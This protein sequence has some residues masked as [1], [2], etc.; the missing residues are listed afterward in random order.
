MDGFRIN[1]PGGEISRDSQVSQP[2]APPSVTSQSFDPRLQTTPDYGALGPDLDF[3]KCDGASSTPAATGPANA[4]PASATLLLLGFVTIGLLTMMTGLTVALIFAK[5]GSHVGAWEKIS[6]IVATQKDSPALAAKF[7]EPDLDGQKP[8]KQAEILLTRAVSHSDGSSAQIEEQIQSRIE[9][10][11]GKVKW[12]SQLSQLTMAAFNSEDENV[13]SSAI[14]VQL[15]AYGLGKNKSSVD[16]LVRKADSPD[17]AQK[18][19]ALWALGL[20]GNR[21]IASDRVVQVL[22]EHIAGA[23]KDP[24]EDSRHWAVEGLAL[25]GNSSSI[26]PLL[27]AMRDDPSPLVRERAACSLAEC[28]MLTR[29]QRLTAVPQLINYTDDPAL[30]AQTQAWAFQALSDITRQRLPRDS[31][32]WRHW[33][34]TT[35]AS[36]R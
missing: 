14:E 5:S 27:E 36:G 7:S 12:N 8:Q 2:L 25:V 20:L 17:H 10:W 19:W 16:F 23:R 28:G 35:V 34:Q 18:N 11:R 26:A 24:D 22:S 13:R 21:G 32:A 9:G 15:A 30:D 33:Y 6:A 3:A 4:R 29:E 1:L 31:A